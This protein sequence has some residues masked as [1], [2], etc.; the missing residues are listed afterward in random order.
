MLY[1]VYAE[2][3]ARRTQFVGKRQGK[4][5]FPE[6]FGEGRYFLE[7]VYIDIRLSGNMDELTFGA[8]LGQLTSL[9]RTSCRGWNTRLRLARQESDYRSH[10]GT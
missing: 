5:V 4:R 9:R 3:P 10:A 7:Y 2:T 6:S 8:V 1:E